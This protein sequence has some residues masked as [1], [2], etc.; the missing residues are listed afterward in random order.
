MT[1]LILRMLFCFL[2]GSIPFAVLAMVGSGVDIRK[3]GSGNPGF[4]NVLRVN[5]ARA[6][7]ALL[8]DMG[9]GFVAVWLV[10]HAWPMR[11][12]TPGEHLGILNPVTLGWAYGFAAVLGHCFS[13]FL[14]FG[15]GKG[16][17]TSGGVMLV[18]YPLWAAIA[19]AYFTAARITA[20]KLK[21]REAGTIASLTTWVLFSLLMLAFVG[22]HDALAAALM[23]LFL[24]WR[25]KKN[26]GKLLTPAAVNDVEVRGAGRSDADPSL[27]ADS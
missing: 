7:L 14:K 12:V 6:V 17:A 21:W 23:T 8:G 26:L 24:I 19:L 13:P 3:V 10:L 11:A 5:K 15:G 16:I 27:T 1:A 25:H 18:L 9:K 20:G 4:N 2:A 22:G